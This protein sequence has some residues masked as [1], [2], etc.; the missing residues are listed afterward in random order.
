MM[1]RLTGNAPGAPPP[2]LTR[3]EVDLFRGLIVERTGIQFL[4]RRTDAL[5]R[6]VVAAARQ[7]G[8]RNR[9]EYYKLLRENPTDSRLWEDLIHLVTVGET[10]FFRDDAQMAALRNSVLPRLAAIHAGDRRLRLWSAGCASGEEPY[11]I[12]MLLQEVIPN[13]ERWTIQIL[14]TDINKRALD[15]ARKAEFR[16]WSFRRCDPRVKKRYFTERNGRYHLHE[17]VR[18]MVT[19]R[20][21]NL[22]EDVYPALATDTAAMDLIICR[23]VAIYLDEEVIRDVTER[24]H[25]C[26][27]PHGWLVVSAAEAPGIMSNRFEPRHFPGAILYQRAQEPARPEASFPPMGREET[28]PVSF[29]IAQRTNPGRSPAFQRAPEPVAGTFTAQTAPEPPPRPVPTVAAVASVQAVE[30]PE[31]TYHKCMEF[32]KQGEYEKAVEGLRSIVSTT[33]D[34]PWPLFQMARAHANMGRLEQAMEWCK[35]A[36]DADP[37]LEETHYTL[38]LIHQEAGRL[39]EALAHLKKTVYLNFEFVLAH[40]T[41]SNILRQMGRDDEAARH[42]SHALRMAS[43]LPPDDVV[44]GSDRLTAAQLLG[45][46]RVE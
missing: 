42:K 20:P 39:D 38:A 2:P 25:K 31:G 15:T 17:N 13:A 12:A 16:E 44:K 9:R 27:L 29:R 7:S 21:L 11:S 14:A 3:E 8:A 43:K 1:A 24:F 35:K 37:L 30:D 18:R 45:M 34:N 23:N 19:F 4:H 41:I 6:G 36:V 5:V 28:A 10:Y 26:L 46:L 33:P 32:M 22:S 40:F